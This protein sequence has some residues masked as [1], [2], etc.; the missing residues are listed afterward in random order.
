MAAADN[1]NHDVVHFAWRSCNP[2]SLAGA[3]RPGDRTGL[4]IL[5]LDTDELLNHGGRR[6]V[7]GVELIENTREYLL[8]IDKKPH[9]ILGQ[10]D[11]NLTTQQIAKW[12]VQRWMLPRIEKEAVLLRIEGH[13]FVHPIRHG[14]RVQ[15][16]VAPF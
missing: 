8:G 16:P 4:D 12:W 11:S 3:Q 13:N 7:Y 9:F 15:M 2:L 10:R 14:A 6:L 1:R 5:G